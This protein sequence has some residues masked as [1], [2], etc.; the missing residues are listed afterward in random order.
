MKLLFGYGTLRSDLGSYSSPPVLMGKACYSVGFGHVQGQ[1][2][3]IQ[4]SFGVW[5]GVLEAETRTEVYG[6]V[7]VIP[8]NMWWSIDRREGL[9]LTPPMY[10]RKSVAVTLLDGYSVGAEIYF[11]NPDANQFLDFVESGDWRDGL[12]LPP[13]NKHYSPFEDSMEYHES[14]A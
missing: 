7:F 4:S 13:P 6:E 5:A 2:W 1:L 14:F 10:I 3:R 9:N 11:I 8:E 12:N